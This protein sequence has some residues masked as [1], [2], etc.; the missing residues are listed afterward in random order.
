MLGCGEA[1]LQSGMGDGWLWFRQPVKIIEAF[2]VDEVLPYLQAVER[3]VEESGLYAAGF[4]TYEAAP[5]FDPVMRVRQPPADLPL[6]WFALYRPADV[7]REE[8][9]RPASPPAY[10]LSDWR[11]TVS[12]QTHNQ[13]IGHI[14]EQIAQGYTYQVNYTFR[15]RA[16]F[17]GDPW[18]LFLDLAEAQRCDHAAYINAGRFAVCSAS[19]ELFF[20]LEG[21][22]LT[23][24]PMKGTAARGRTLAEDEGQAEWLFHSAKNRA[25]NVMI[26][27]MIRNDMGRAAQIGTVR[28]PQLF[29]V[30][31]YPTVWQMTSTVTAQTERPLSEIMRA[32]FPCA[33]ITGAP[34][35]SAMGIIAGLEE[36]PR[37]LYTGAVGYIAP[38]RQAHFNVA[39]R[40]VVIDQ[41]SGAA[42]Y[43]VGGGIVWDSDAAEEYEECQIKA[44]VLTAQPPDFS[45]LET[46]L[47]QPAE[48]YFLLDYHLER[49]ARSAQYFAIELD[50][51][52]VKQHLIDITHDLAPEAHKVRLLVAQDGRFTAE[53][54]PWDN[55]GPRRTWRVRL[56]PEAVDSGN[57][58]LYHKTTNRTI[59]ETARRA[60]PDCDDVILWN[61]K[62]EATEA[63]IANIVF[64]LG[65]ER[66]TPPVSSG[67]LPGVFRQWLLDEGV[68]RE[69]PISLKEA[70]QCR[71]FYLIN[72]VRKWQPAEWRP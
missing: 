4:L 2:R 50:A 56:S 70:V 41:E 26:V 63:T 66:V 47:W 14:K 22:R 39:I 58:F 71:R 31:R 68:I 46:M 57:P 61:E 49:L 23:S 45:L 33:S 64:E 72:S 35:V 29:A 62:G 18:G 12:R 54:T 24:R 59:Y 69:R 27:D 30:E 16:D 42:E 9:A 13:A 8:L 11:P 53:A 32:L 21:E 15:L 65:G 60:C 40:T 5:A 19:P 10:S 17:Q 55:A 38:R 20:S 48:G 51:A 28:V 6:L 37:G 44:R 36:S 25:E 67:L 52:R 34:K 3:E 1:A 43:G 7:T